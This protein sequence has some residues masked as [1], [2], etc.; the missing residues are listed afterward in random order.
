[1]IT[2]SQCGQCTCF[3]SWIV[4]NIKKVVGLIYVLLQFL[5]GQG[6]S[7]GPWVVNNSIKWMITLFSVGSV[8]ALLHGLPII[9]KK[10]VGLISVLLHFLSGQ[11]VS[12][13]PWVVKNSIKKSCWS[14]LGWEK[15]KHP[16]TKNYCC[17][18]L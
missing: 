6:A 8:H 11:C 10:V 12:F 18:H 16:E 13:G 15:C 1:M 17:Y 3:A 5:S 9:Q 4:N 14:L 2:L 7:F